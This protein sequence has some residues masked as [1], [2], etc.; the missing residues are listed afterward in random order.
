MNFEPQKFFIGLVDFFSIFLPGALVIFV[1]EHGLLSDLIPE[2]VRQI[3]GIEGWMVVFFGS[4]LV[5]H[6]I[7]LI[8]SIVLDG[9]YGRLRSG[10]EPQQRWRL[11]KGELLSYRTTRWL[12]D[13]LFRS[14]ADHA[15]SR[16]IAIKDHYLAPLGEK[17]AVNAFQWSK[18]RLSLAHPDAIAMVHRFEAD[19]KFFRSLTVVLFFLALGF[20]LAAGVTPRNSAITFGLLALMVFSFWRFV[21]QRTK[22]INQAYWFILTIEAAAENGFRQDASVDPHA[23]A[24]GVVYKPGKVDKY[25]LVHT[26]KEPHDWVLPKGHIEP[27]ESVKETAVR[28]VLEETGVWARVDR[29]LEDVTYTHE[30]EIIHACYFLMETLEERKPAPPRRLGRKFTKL[31]LSELRKHAWFTLGEALKANPDNK[32]MG[33][34]LTKAG[35]LRSSVPVP[36]A[37]R[38]MRAA[39]GGASAT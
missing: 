14:E 7:F 30:G 1:L 4:Y 27:N 9:A 20:P 24:G 23:R 8:G 6:F 5:G 25:L 18:A 29:E 35:E 3:K 16:A 38:R 34:L 39:D 22:A 10:T 31:P 2:P 28:E 37:R 33:G 36:H 19:S 21:D 12:A 26:T 17:L 15:F 32:E 11:S 13:H